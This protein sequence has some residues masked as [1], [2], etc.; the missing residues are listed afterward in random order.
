MMEQQRIDYPCE[1]LIALPQ[2]DRHGLPLRK[3]VLFF[4]EDSELVRLEDELGLRRRR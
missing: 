4:N 2:V 3:G 1:T